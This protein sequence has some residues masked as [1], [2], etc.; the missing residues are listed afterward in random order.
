MFLFFHRLGTNLILD[1]LKV[2]LEKP[3]GGRTR[4]ALARLIVDGKFNAAAIVAEQERLMDFGGD[5]LSLILADVSVP[6]RRRR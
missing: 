6:R 5:N 1:W 2:I 3:D 4:S